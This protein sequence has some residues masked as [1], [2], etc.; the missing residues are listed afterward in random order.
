[1]ILMR[2]FY[3]IVEQISIKFYMIRLKKITDLFFV[4]VEKIMGFL[5]KLMPFYLDFYQDMVYNEIKAINLSKDTKILHIGSGS[6]PATAILYVKKTDNYVT[7]IDIDKKSIKKSKIVLKSLDLSNKVTLV[8]AEGIDFDYSSFDL[9]IVSQGV[10]PCFD[11]LKKIN[12]DMKKDSVVIYRTFSLKDGSLSQNDF[13]IKDFFDVV[14]II[15]HEKNGLLISVILR[16]K[17]FMN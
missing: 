1:M 10:N 17:N 2:L 5:D 14:K 6:I 7:G 11:I 16:K 8:N 13:F 4:L 3:F 12:N 15:Q 9:I